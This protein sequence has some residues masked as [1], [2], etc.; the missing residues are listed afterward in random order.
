MNYTVK[1]IKTFRGM[2]GTG[3]NA[4]LYR[5]NKKVAFVI[6]D[7]QGGELRYEWE[8][9]KAER[10]RIYGKNYAGEEFTYKGTPEEKL[11]VEYAASLPGL[12]H[13]G[14]EIPC[15]PD[16]LIEELINKAENRK[17]L[18]KLSKTKTLFKYEHDKDGQWRVYNKPFDVNIIEAL[19]KA[20]KPKIVSYVNEKGEEVNL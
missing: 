12:K 20:S 17:H 2:E 8:D 16:L 15:S 18:K 19:K 14:I 11:L 4:N 3:F 7:A 5:G 1:N 6:D 10:V 13:G 9:Y